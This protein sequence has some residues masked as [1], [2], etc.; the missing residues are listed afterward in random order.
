MQ[1]ID[2]QLV[3][4][5]FHG[6]CAYCGDPLH[7]T[8][9]QV[10]HIL[11]KANFLHHIENYWNVPDFLKHLTVDDLNHPDNLFPSCGYCNN[12]KNGFHL[13][14]FREELSLQIS[15]LNARSPNYRIA[16]RFGQ[17][18]ETPTPIVFYFEKQ[19]KI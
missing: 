4:D 9:M 10:D 1:G 7:I 13:E 5:K 3:Y 6:H 12:W 19:W 15:R 2:R 14:L 18:I 8:K 17:L 11:S 16:K